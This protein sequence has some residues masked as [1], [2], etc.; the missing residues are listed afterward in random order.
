MKKLI[1]IL[2]IVLVLTFGISLKSMAA[3][4]G[5]F[6]IDAQGLSIFGGYDW[7]QWSIGVDYPVAKNLVCGIGLA[8][9][10]VIYNATYKLTDYILLHADGVFFNER[11]V[12]MFG[13]FLNLKPVNNLRIYTGGGLRLLTDGYD[14]YVEGGLQ[15]VVIDD[16]QI[17]GNLA[18][19]I[20]GPEMG[21]GLE[22]G[23]SYTF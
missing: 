16:L 20:G 10:S 18:A 2:V 21:A 5:P 9:E 1:I 8:S 3:M 23:A 19:T 13:G 17:Y 22:V 14:Y 7:Y 11:S 12:N 4:A 15:L 6:L